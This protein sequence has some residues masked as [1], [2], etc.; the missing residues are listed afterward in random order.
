MTRQPQPSVDRANR[1][2]SIPLGA[3]APLDDGS[4]ECAVVAV[5]R[6]HIAVALADGQSLTRL[7]QGGVTDPVGGHHGEYR[8]ALLS[9]AQTEHV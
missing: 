9:T 3:V 2:A 7:D 4:A 1:T 8:D 6:G 5:E